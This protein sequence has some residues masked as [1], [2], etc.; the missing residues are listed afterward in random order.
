MDDARVKK[1]TAATRAALA[2]TGEPATIE[3]FNYPD[4]ERGA[5]A[6]FWVRGQEIELHSVLEGREIAK[7]RASALDDLTA[8]FV[9]AAEVWRGVGVVREGW[10][11]FEYVDTFPPYARLPKPRESKFFPPRSMVTFLDP[12]HAPRADEVKE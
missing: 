7:Y 8:A 1:V 5:W 4:S 3:Y 10:I 2:A 12:G 11:R 6:Q 9:R